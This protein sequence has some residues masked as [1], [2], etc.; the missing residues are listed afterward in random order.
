L[1]GEGN[2][3]V[4]GGGGV[5]TGAQGDGD[6]VALQRIENV[7]EAFVLSDELL[8]ALNGQA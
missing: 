6:D 4:N 7:D 5:D 8:D 3:A 2:D 1:G